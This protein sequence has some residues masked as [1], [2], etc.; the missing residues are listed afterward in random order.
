VLII[1]PS[2]HCADKKAD[3]ATAKSRQIFFIHLYY[4][5][6]NTTVISKILQHD[7]K[8]FLSV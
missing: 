4:F 1:V 5:I 3:E 6:N 7:G 8:Y 2:L